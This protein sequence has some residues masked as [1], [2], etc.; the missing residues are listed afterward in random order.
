MKITLKRSDLILLKEKDRPEQIAL[1]GWHEFVDSKNQF[2]SWGYLGKQNKGYGL[3]L[4][5]I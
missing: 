5:H 2:I 3:S 1:S 4:I